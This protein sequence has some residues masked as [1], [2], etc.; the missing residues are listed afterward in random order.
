MFEAFRVGP[1]ETGDGNFTLYVTCSPAGA[2]SAIA[3]DDR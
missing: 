1:V 2:V 3:A